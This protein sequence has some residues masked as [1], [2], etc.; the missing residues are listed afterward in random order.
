MI[1]REFGIFILEDGILL[2]IVFVIFYD[3]GEYI[4]VV[5]N[6]V[7]IIERKYNFKVYVFLVIKDKE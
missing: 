4:C 6:E 7:G 3:N 2:V 1:G 5:V